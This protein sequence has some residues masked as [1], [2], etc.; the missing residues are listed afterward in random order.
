MTR[1]WDVII[2]GGGLAGYV[3][4]NYLIKT[5]RSILLIEKGKIVGGRARTTKMNDQCFNLGPHALYKKR[6]SHGYS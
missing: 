4:A 6:K 2:V 3:A 5:N 1:K